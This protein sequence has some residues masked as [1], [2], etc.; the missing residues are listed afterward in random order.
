MRR[1]FRFEPT[2]PE[3]DYGTVTDWLGQPNG[4][5]APNSANFTIQASS[6]WHIVGTG[7]FNGDHRDDILW[8]SDGGQF[9]DWLGQ[10]DG[11]LVSS[12]QSYFANVDTHW[13]VQP[14]E[15]FL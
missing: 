14:V 1:R 11:A 9:S 5:F 4:G 10:T 12:A 3:K 8:Q 6:S 2:D 13:H 7:D 15:T